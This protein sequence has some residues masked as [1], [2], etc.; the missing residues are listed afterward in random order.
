MKHSFKALAATI[1]LAFVTSTASAISLFSHQFV[2]K[3]D[4]H[5][6]SEP[7]ETTLTTSKM[8]K[9]GQA[10][11]PIKVRVR[12]VRKIVRGCRYEVEVTN[13]DKARRLSYD[14]PGLGQKDKGHKLDP[15][16]SDVYGTD[17]FLKKNCPDEDAC[18]NGQC[19]YALEFNDVKVKE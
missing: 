6:W 8:E 18:A 19:E 11:I 16:E 14:M 3:G 12:V 5:E 2:F 13:M 17:T 7:I 10:P 15:G 4:V 9:N 1:V